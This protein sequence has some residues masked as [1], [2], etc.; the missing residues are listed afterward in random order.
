MNKYGDD[1]DHLKYR[2]FVEIVFKEEE[3]VSEKTTALKIYSLLTDRFKE[4]R[5]AFPTISTH[6]KKTD[7]RVFI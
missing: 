7:T 1:F 2:H 6:R 4:N 3:G 5:E